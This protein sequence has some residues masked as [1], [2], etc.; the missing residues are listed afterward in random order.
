MRPPVTGKTMARS[1]Q[2]TLTRAIALLRGSGIETPQMDAELLLASAMECARLDLISHPEKA[3]TD[4]QLSHFEEMLA[5]RARR[6]PLA[7]LTGSREFYGIS[8]EVSDAV[9]VPRPETELLVDQAVRRLGDAPVRVADVGVGSGAI[10]VALAVSLPNA[11]VFGT[12]I[13]T[14]ALEVAGRNVAKHHLTDRVRLF[15]GDLVDPLAALQIEFDA[16]VSNPPYVPM[17]DIPTLQPEV[18]QWEPR[19]AL[20]GGEDGLDVIR[21]LIPAAAQLLRPAGF[22]A[23]E[24]GM[25]QAEAV[26]RI[27]AEAGYSGTEVASDLAGI[28]RVVVCLK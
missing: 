3:L 20:D 1:I 28:E 22:A 2:D 14:D 21:R 25:G 9:L 16:I 19:T 8:I 24:I 12:D 6:C 26:R 15:C 18:S 5:R 7:Y 4:R 17:G 13:S 27:A 23:I 10:A 11:T